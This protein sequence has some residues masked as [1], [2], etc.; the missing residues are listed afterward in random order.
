M[1]CHVILIQLQVFTSTNGP[2]LFV[3]PTPFSFTTIFKSSS[4]N[5]RLPQYAQTN[6]VNVYLFHGD[7]G[8]QIMNW[9]SYPNPTDQAGSLSTLVNDSWWGT[10]GTSWAGT[11]V[12]F[13]FYWVITPNNEDLGNSLP[14]ST[15]TAV[16]ESSSPSFAYFLFIFYRNYVRRL[17]TRYAVPIHNRHVKHVYRH[18]CFKLARD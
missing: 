10:R 1:F 14:Q 15:F 13:L 2:P 16:R 5:S 4:G 7:S 6:L 17:R 8:E 9:M 18:R 12:P 3:S 11:D